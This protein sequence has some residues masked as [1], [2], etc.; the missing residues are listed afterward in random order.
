MR[1]YTLMIEYKGND[2][3]SEEGKGN[4]ENELFLPEDDMCHLSAWVAA[5]MSECQFLIV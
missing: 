3:E 2:A 5:R 4:V 1:F